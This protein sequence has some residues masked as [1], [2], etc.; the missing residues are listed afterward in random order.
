MMRQR[1]ETCWWETTYDP[2]LVGALADGTWTFDHDVGP[3]KKFFTSE[4]LQSHVDAGGIAVFRDIIFTQCD[5]QGHF[6]LSSQIVFNN[7][8]FINCD[9]SLSTWENVKFS[10]CTFST[11]SLG[12]ATIRDCEFRGCIWQDISFSPNAF[13]LHDTYIS[14]PSDFIKSATTNLDPV[15]LEAKN[16]S[17]FE[18]K[19]RLETT[20]AIIA[21]RVW[22]MLQNEGSEDTYYEALKTFLLQNATSEVSSIKLSRSKERKL[23]RRASLMFAQ[24]VWVCEREILRL[25]GFVNRWGASVVRPV[26]FIFLNFFVFTVLYYILG[27]ESISSSA[28]RSFDIA[29]VAGYTNY[30][31]ESDSL[32][33]L[34]QNIQ[35]IISIILYTLFF[36]T[37]INRVSR[38][39]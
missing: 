7:C 36:S 39:R 12:Q 6:H 27:V 37:I 30:G 20:K 8:S 4:A 24:N 14:N 10:S 29:I 38:A 19:M 11:V 25:F 28:Q 18:Q 32:K 9:L 15:V 23:R 33:L 31:D 2:K 22:K 17:A 21:R 34:M 5:F 13:E 16:A 1:R 3:T 35:I 26:A